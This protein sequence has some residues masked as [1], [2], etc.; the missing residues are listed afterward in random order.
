MG[1]SL[2]FLAVKGRTPD[3]VQRRLGLTDTGVVAGE[4]D[5]PQPA[6]RGATLPDGWY[7]VLL[8]DADHRFVMEDEI[9]ARLSQDCEVVACRLSEGVMASGCLAWQDG[10]KLWEVEHEPDED[11]A[12]RLVVE[13]TPPAAFEAIAA[14]LR[15]QQEEEDGGDPEMAVDY[16]WEIPIE[17][18]H[19]LCRYR[20]DFSYFDWGKPEF[21]ILAEGKG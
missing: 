8:K 12:N 3:E 15:A 17:L 18:A 14:R 16:I 2:S 13:G 4:W 11:D 5:Y 20:H 10:A 9:L 1:M 6:V 7:L 19:S 21:R